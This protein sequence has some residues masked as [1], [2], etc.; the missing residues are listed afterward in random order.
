MSDSASR[1]V[2]PSDIEAVFATGQL[3]A[4]VAQDFENNEILMLAWMNRE[5]LIETLST[6]EVTYWSRS[7]NQLWKKGETSGHTQKVIEI[8]FDCD[9]DAIVMKVEQVGAA[10]HNGTRSCFINKIEIKSVNNS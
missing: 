4:A 3:I 8:F 6:G 2:I 1:A 10:C 5:S 7:R 9:A